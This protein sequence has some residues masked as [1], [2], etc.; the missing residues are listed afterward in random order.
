MCI[1]DSADVDGSH[2]RTLL[3]TFFFKEMRGLIENGNLYIARPPLFKIKRGK[4]ELYISDENKLQRSLIKYGAEDVTFK[5]AQGSNLNEKNLV[6]I[7]N[8]ISEV[9]EIYNKVPDRYDKKFLDQIAIA[10]CLDINKFI[11]SKEKTKEAIN[12]ISKR[13]NVSRPDYDRGWKGEYSKEKG[14]IF[15]RELRGLRDN[16][17]IDNK[18][19]KSQIIQNL[20]SSYADL[21]QLFLSLIHISEPTRH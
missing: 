7:L 20:N 19:L 16:I 10:G 5:T 11:E 2:I 4:E 9:I 12:Y 3:L 1:R 21:Y 18:L 17:I 13:V 14:F 6:D 8:K 15:R